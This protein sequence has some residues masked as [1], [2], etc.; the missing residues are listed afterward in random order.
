MADGDVA[1]TMTRLDTSATGRGSVAG[2][3]RCTLGCACVDAD[4]MRHYIGSSLLSE[5][6]ATRHDLRTH[7]RLVGAIGCLPSGPFRAS[8]FLQAAILLFF[9]L[10]AHSLPC[11]PAPTPEGGRPCPASRNWPRKAV[12]FNITSVYAAV[13]DGG[14][15]YC[16]GVLV[17]SF[18]RREVLRRNVLARQMP[19]DECARQMQVDDCAAGPSRMMPNSPSSFDST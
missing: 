5:Y 2:E 18:A 7:L 13:Q 11:F 4:D 12:R 17:V 9:A 8:T 10:V 1:L 6:F 19:V 16:Q 14:D 15:N 3:C